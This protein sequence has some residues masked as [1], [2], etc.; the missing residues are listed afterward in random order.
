MHIKY[1]VAFA[2]LAITCNLF[3][4]ELYEKRGGKKQVK[5]GHHTYTYTDMTKHVNPKC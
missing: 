1:E 5:E 3:P 2:L 4:R